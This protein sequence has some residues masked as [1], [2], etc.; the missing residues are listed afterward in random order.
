MSKNIEFTEQEV[1]EE[2]AKTWRS[3]S[4]ATTGSLAP[5][6]V[7]TMSYASTQLT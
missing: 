6:L 2:A 5:S 3:I 4:V 7:R 1:R